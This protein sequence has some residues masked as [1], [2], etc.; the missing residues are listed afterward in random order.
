MCTA[1]LE[2]VLKPVQPRTLI[3]QGPAF[4][5]DHAGPAAHITTATTIATT[6]VNMFP[7][8]RLTSGQVLG[9]PEFG[10]RL[11]VPSASLLRLH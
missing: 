8:W 9:G 5:P 10:V 3:F 4:Q 11:R 7:K 1:V 6:I 2:P